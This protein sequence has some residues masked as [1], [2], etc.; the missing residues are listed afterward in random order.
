MFP[1]KPVPYTPGVGVI[2]PQAHV[3][4]NPGGAFNKTPFRDYAVKIE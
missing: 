4:Y 1:A 3:L 2:E